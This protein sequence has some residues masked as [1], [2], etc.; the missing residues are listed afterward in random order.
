MNWSVHPASLSSNRR[1]RNTPGPLHIDLQDGTPAVGRTDSF[2]L[3]NRS[4][5]VSRGI[6][7]SLVSLNKEKS[8]T[9]SDERA[10]ISFDN[11]EGLVCFSNRDSSCSSNR[12]SLLSFS[13][14][15]RLLSGE[16]ESLLFT[17]YVRTSSVSNKQ[18][19]LLYPGKPEST[20]FSEF[21][22]DSD[23][24][25][26]TI[27][28]EEVRTIHLPTQEVE[29]SA[30]LML[31]TVKPKPNSI[32][33]APPSPP[34]EPS[35]A[36]STYTPYSP[37]TLGPY[38]SAGDQFHRQTYSSLTTMPVRLQF[39]KDTANDASGVLSE[40]GSLPFP[41]I[42]QSTSPVVEKQLAS[43]HSPMI[44]HAPAIQQDDRTPKSNS[45][46]DI[47]LYLWT[48][49]GRSTPIKLF[50]R[51]VGEHG[52]KVMVRVGGG[53]VD[54]GDVSD[55]ASRCSRNGP[56][57]ERNSIY[58]NMPPLMSELPYLTWANKLWLN[59]S[60]LIGHDH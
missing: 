54:L 9:S 43:D 35:P 3:P 38:S 52:N 41:L 27:M 42:S 17:S 16:R 1:W 14:S 50:V 24:P 8:S 57:D 10:N 47:K 53:W 12:E 36:I 21:T 40:D 7:E 55:L 20:T 19:S 18:E 5:M 11:T 46:S 44:S 15:N 32:V 37:Y 34:W 31:S 29:A 33:V 45:E 58:T 56:A 4:S 25:G 48:Q 49:P 30:Q 60:S 51:L 59:P 2:P 6:R 39:H 23:I 13:D 26:S 28:T 22:V